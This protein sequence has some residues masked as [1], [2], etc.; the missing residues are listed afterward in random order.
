MSLTR[1]PSGGSL[2]PSED[3]ELQ[4]VKGKPDGTLVALIIIV[5]CALGLLGLVALGADPAA[6]PGVAAVVAAVGIA[7]ARMR[8]D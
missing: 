4:T 2:P 5:A 7:A 3:W 1:Q 6:L 8:H